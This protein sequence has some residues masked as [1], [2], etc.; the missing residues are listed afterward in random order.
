MNNINAPEMDDKSARRD[1]LIKEIERL[2]GEAQG[3]MQKE[4][5]EAKL[6]EI[7][8]KLEGLL[9]EIKELNSEDSKA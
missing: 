4:E 2:Q 7:N 6:A 9:A 8:A 3:V 5:S 1:Q